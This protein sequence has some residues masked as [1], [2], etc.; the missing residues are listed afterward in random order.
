MSDMEMQGRRRLKQRS[1]RR[2]SYCQENPSYLRKRVVS[3]SRKQATRGRCV[4]LY[5]CEYSIVAQKGGHVTPSNAMR[6]MCVLKVET[7][8]PRGVYDRCLASVGL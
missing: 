5:A 6:L 8:W 1:R 2:A 4:L 7:K 3:G